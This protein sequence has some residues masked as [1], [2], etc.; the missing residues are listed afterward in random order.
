[1]RCNRQGARMT[2]RQV[3]LVS[4]PTGIAQ[5]GNFAIREVP[6]VPPAAAL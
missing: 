4:R 1:M 2:N 5:A 3:V 6:V